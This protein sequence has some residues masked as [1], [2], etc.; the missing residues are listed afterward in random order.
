MFP[1]HSFCKVNKPLKW[2][3][4]NLW[5]KIPSVCKV[6][7]SLGRISWPNRSLHGK[8]GGVTHVLTARVSGNHMIISSHPYLAQ[9]CFLFFL[10]KKKNNIPGNKHSSILEQGEQIDV[11]SS[12]FPGMNDKRF[13]SSSSGAVLVNQLSERKIRVLVHSICQF[14]WCKYSYPGQFQGID[15]LTT[16]SPNS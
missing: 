4:W 5:F 10:E 2:W 12:F 8:G 15:S 6:L 7:H 16:R 14:P 1:P 13:F 9:S 11:S 3:Q